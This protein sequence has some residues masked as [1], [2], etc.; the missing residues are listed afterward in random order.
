MREETP[1]TRICAR[2]HLKALIA[3]DIH[4]PGLSQG[5]SARDSSNLDKRRISISNLPGFALLGRWD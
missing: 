3:D 1:D 2:S 5:Y 4:G